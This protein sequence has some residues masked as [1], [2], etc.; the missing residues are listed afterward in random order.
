MHGLSYSF[1]LYIISVHYVVS[2]LM[3]LW[4]TSSDIMKYHSTEKYVCTAHTHFYTHARI[5]VVDM[6]DKVLWLLL[7]FRAV[8]TGNCVKMPN[9]FHSF[10]FRNLWHVSYIPFLST[11]CPLSSLCIY[12][13]L[14]LIWTV[15]S[16]T[17]Q[18]EANRN[19]RCN[20]DLWYCFLISVWISL[21]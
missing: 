17:L 6:R 1:N 13:L 4:Y 3:R 15:Q 7:K 14:R 2:S 19:V 21:N 5:Q 20:H 16:A 12:F 10:Y 11:L 9:Y 18:L 8:T